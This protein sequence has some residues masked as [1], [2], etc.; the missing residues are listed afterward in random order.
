[1]KKS[2]TIHDLDAST[3]KLIEERAKAEGRSLNKTI[4]A[5]LEQALGVKPR[6]LRPD[7]LE[8]FSEFL[9]KWQ[10]SDVARFER[11]TKALRKIDDEDWQ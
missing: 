7:R 2:I 5:L 3:A 6:E 1:M 10:A 9:G 11:A 4:Q 8:I